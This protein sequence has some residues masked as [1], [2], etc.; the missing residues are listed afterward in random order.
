MC[1]IFGAGHC[2]PVNLCQASLK[3]K[4]TEHNCKQ[5]GMMYYFALGLPSS[6]VAGKRRGASGHGIS[7]E[8]I[9]RLPVM[10]MCMAMHAGSG[11]NGSAT[12][13]SRF[14]LFHSSHNK[15]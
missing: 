9:H 13:F 4:E 10:G 6:W 5:A 2:G 7:A 1:A 12:S 3:R 15:S 14:R 8:R 11:M